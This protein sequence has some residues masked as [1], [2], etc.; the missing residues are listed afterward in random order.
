MWL[1]AKL[2]NNRQPLHTVCDTDKLI[3]ILSKEDLFFL[4][5]VANHLPSSVVHTLR[6]L[7]KTQDSLQYDLMNAIGDTTMEAFAAQYNGD[8]VGLPVQRDLALGNV[9]LELPCHS[10]IKR[11]GFEAIPLGS[12]EIALVINKTTTQESL[13]NLMQCLLRY[14]PEQRVYALPVFLEY[15]KQI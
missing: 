15:V 1:K 6:E 12:D 5:R 9:T 10:S 3:N 14:L 11:Y 8:A 7:D 13:C 2:D 4:T